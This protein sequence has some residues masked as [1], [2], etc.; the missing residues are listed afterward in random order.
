MHQ[1]LKLQ[2]HTHTGKRLAHHHTSWRAL[3]L[4]LVVFGGLV[5]GMTERAVADT[6][7]IKGKI[8]APP[9]TQAAVITAP[10]T[11]I[12]ALQPG[13]T[14]AGTCQYS[15]HPLTHIVE[16]YS[17][18][19]LLGTTICAV[20]GN[21]SVTSELLAGD[22]TL[23]ARTVNIT[24]DYGPD[25]APVVVNYPFPGRAGEPS[26][27]TTPGTSQY[28]EVP[29]VV[30]QPGSMQLVSK[31]GYVV[32]GPGKAAEW[33]GSIQGGRGPFLYEINWG[34]GTID[35]RTVDDRSEQSFMHMYTAF[36]SYIITVT[37]TDANKAT[38]TRT[39]AAVT[40]FLGS[41]NTSMVSVPFWG[42][43]TS[44][45]W[46]VYGAYLLLIALV[47]LAWYDARYGLLRTPAPARVPV[48]PTRSGTV[49]MTAVE[50]R[51]KR[52]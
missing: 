5:V 29:V 22:N 13:V 23:I 43:N 45:V 30:K 46:G 24:D 38:V 27:R 10:P 28:G 3:F 35:K 17:N 39:F 40:P 16:V 34:D 48:A 37:V 49:R 50:K 33:M 47:G 42:S 36:D 1:L 7:V 4:I 41:G 19:V 14:V 32:Y 18:G 25:S 8:P 11:G 44:I 12:V 52:R 21:F 9:V 6:L 51:K 31:S 2:H 15:A 26:T 20:G